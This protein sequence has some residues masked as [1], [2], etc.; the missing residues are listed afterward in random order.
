[1]PFPTRVRTRRQVRRAGVGADVVTESYDKGEERASLEE[2]VLA[3]RLA[4][5][6]SPGG[7]AGS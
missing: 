7:P 4:D 6:N 5:A 2:V 1:M 3:A